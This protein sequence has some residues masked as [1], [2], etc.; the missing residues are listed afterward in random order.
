MIILH[1]ESYYFALCA[2]FVLIFMCIFPTLFDPLFFYK[3]GASSK[4]V[5]TLNN[6]AQH[7][8]VKHSH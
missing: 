2:L 1:A 7:A 4:I 6:S 8:L 3:S 5:Q